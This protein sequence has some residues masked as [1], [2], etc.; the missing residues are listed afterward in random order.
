MTGAT[1]R[2]LEAEMT[3]QY[4]GGNARQAES[5]FG[6]GRHTAEVGLAERRTGIMCLGAQSTCSGRP[7][8]EDAH[9][10]VAEALQQQAEAYAQ[11]DPMFRT[12]L[13]S[14]R[15]TA[16]GAL[17]GLRAQGYRDDQLPAPSTMAAVLNRLDFRLH[18]VIKAKPQKKIKETNAIFDNIKKGC[19]R[20]GSGRGPT[21]E[22]R[23]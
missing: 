19:P 10:Q 12:L 14:T 17:E 16:K 21:L 22:H 11:Q 2:A 7:R 1:R 23:L 13:A 18:K 20:H 15:L 4:C 9:P 3:M 6:W 5:V 8:W